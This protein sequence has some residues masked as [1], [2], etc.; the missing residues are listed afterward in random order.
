[1]K[2][3]TL[4]DAYPIPHIHDLVYKTAKYK[5]FSKLVLK[6]MYH[7]DPLKENEEQYT[8]FEADGQLFHFTMVT[9]GL[10]HTI[11][12]FQRTVNSVVAYN[13]LEAIF[14]IDDVIIC[15]ES[16]K[17]PDSDLHLFKQVASMDSL[18]INTKKVSVQSK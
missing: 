9:F 11:A 14:Y 5:V 7:Q 16:K 10:T 1:M 17:D 6:C 12:V 18:T 2:H 3:C 15:K 13:S 8:T 4:L